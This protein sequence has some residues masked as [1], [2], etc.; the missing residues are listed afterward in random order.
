MTDGKKLVLLN[1]KFVDWNDAKLHVT[2]HALLYGS[3][4][5][6][7]IRA[8]A[9]ADGKQLFVFRLKEHV[10]RL[11]NNAKVLRLKATLDVDAFSEKIVELLR[12]NEFHTDAYIRPVIYFGEGEIGLKP[13][14]QSTDYF[15][16][17]VEFGNYFGEARPLNVGISSWVRPSNNSLPPSAKINGSYVNSMLASMDAKESGFDEAI[18]LTQNGFVSEG[19]GENLFIVK[20]G[21]LI[22]PPVSAD[23]LEGITRDSIMSIARNSG[24]EVV[25]R[26]V[27]RTELYTCDELFLCGTAAQISPV[28]S[29]DRRIIGDGKPGEITSKL[30]A[31]FNNAV[32]GKDRNYVGWLSQVYE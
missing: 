30:N 8:Y 29:V 22:T 20:K 5:F 13:L 6:E 4:V 10:V 19:P 26:D 18:M 21:K 15:V 31:S 23:I 1:G 32:R 27:A 12:L 3:A 14:K 28:A 25:E 7:G 17:A 9:S 16:F 2:T 24:L 11:L